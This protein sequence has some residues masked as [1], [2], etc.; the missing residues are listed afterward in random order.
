VIGLSDGIQ[1]NRK[2]RTLLI[3]ARPH[4][5]EPPD[6]GE[7]RMGAVVDRRFSRSRTGCDR[8]ALMLE[9]L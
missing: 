6:I 3:D 4:V 9:W 5:R 1:K 8:R 2:D 7:F